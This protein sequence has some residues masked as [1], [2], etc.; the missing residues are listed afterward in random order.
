MPPVDVSRAP[1]ALVERFCAGPGDRGGLVALLAFLGPL[2][3][4]SST[5]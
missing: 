1:A 2:T 3:T 4:G 5:G